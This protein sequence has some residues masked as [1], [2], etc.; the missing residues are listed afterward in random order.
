M[1]CPE[2]RDIWELRQEWMKQLSEGCLLYGRNPR[3]GNTHMCWMEEGN[4]VE[5]GIAIQ[6]GVTFLGCLECGRSHLCPIATDQCDTCP[7]VDTPDGM[8]VCPMSGKVLHENDMVQIAS[9]NQRSDVVSRIREGKQSK[10]SDATQLMLE[11]SRRLQ[12][13]VHDQRAAANFSGDAR[14]DLYDK[15]A[16]QSVDSKQAYRAFKQTEGNKRRRLNNGSENTKRQTHSK[17]ARS[18]TDFE[19][20]NL[21]QEDDGGD[22]DTTILSTGIEKDLD[23]FDTVSLGRPVNIPTSEFTMDDECWTY[24]FRPIENFFRLYG[25]EIDQCFNAQPATSFAPMQS[26][27]SLSPDSV[28]M[29][30]PPRRD[31]KKKNKKKTK[32]EDE[33]ERVKP[34]LW[35]LNNGDRFGGHGLPNR[36]YMQLYVTHFITH[37]RGIQLAHH[38]SITTASPMSA[39]Y[40][41]NLCDRFLWICHR[42]A[43]TNLETS[44]Y[45]PKKSRVP[46]LMFT[47]LTCL[48]TT[49]HE[50]RD[51]I[52]DSRQFIW[53]KDEWL[54]ACA[55]A[56]LFEL[57]NVPTSLLNIRQ[58]GKLAKLATG[59]IQKLNGCPFSP[60]Q[61]ARFFQPVVQ[62]GC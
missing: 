24:Y 17:D 37:Y 2:P 9:F 33:D 5:V 1:Q 27:P 46:K 4:V 51:P 32:K 47:F 42:Y 53:L 44:P 23:A 57:A 18:W 59:L 43:L 36:L 48:F 50:Q 31:I 7:L 8:I 56:K 34:Y 26:I 40:Y 49:D 3:H 14:G 39:D 45:W 25:N 15:L 55:K 10:N 16:L 58:S 62:Y 6:S 19:N 12:T 52:V 38:P 21:G 61:L 41:I 29:P 35:P 22:D 28:I 30:P 20:G 11:H 60:F 13:Y 54:A